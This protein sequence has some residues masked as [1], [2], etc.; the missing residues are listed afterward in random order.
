[1]GIQV[2]DQH[3]SRPGSQSGVGGQY[4]AIERAITV[5]PLSARVMEAARK[6]TRSALPQSPQ[7][8]GNRA[9]FDA[10]TIGHNPGSHASSCDSASVLGSPVRTALMY[11]GS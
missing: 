3:V 2:Q 8:R 6:S 7:G 5:A 9:P 11:C 1:M 4:E 10:S